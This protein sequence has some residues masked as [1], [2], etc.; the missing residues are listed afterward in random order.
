MFSKIN[1]FGIIYD[2]FCTLKN[3]RNGKIYAPDLVLF[4]LIPL[5][6]SGF[7]SH[8]GFIISANLANVLL[9]CFSI[10]AA[11]LFNLL[12]LIFDIADKVK[13]NNSKSYSLEQ[14]KVFYDLL[15][16]IYINVSFCILISVLSIVLLLG[17]FIDLDSCIFLLI[18]SSVVYFFV[19][20]FILTLFMILK[21]VYALLSQRI[22]DTF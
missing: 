11:L 5:I 13:N 3:Y 21:R 22:N 6:I 17:F 20:V 15:K 19:F 4:F 7:L 9:T 14:S 10:F 2:H 8:R 1:I 18:L 16:E 12:L